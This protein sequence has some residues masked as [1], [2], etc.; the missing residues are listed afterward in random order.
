M[1]TCYKIYSY[2]EFFT[3]HLSSVVHSATDWCF[4]IHVY[5]AK[6]NVEDY[7]QQEVCHWLSAVM[8]WLA[9]EEL[10][11]DRFTGITYIIC[12]NKCRENGTGTFSDYRRR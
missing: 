4:E 7:L 8:L 6:V 2:F 10:I 5:F 12:D 1:H 3:Y 11:Y 9:I